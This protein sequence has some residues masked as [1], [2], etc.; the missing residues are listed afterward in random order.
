MS[1][2]YR[3]PG[4]WSFETSP[5]FAA[6]DRIVSEDGRTVMRGTVSWVGDGV[7]LAAAPNLLRALQMVAALPAFEPDE[8]YG[9]AVLAA[10][11]EA[12]GARGDLRNG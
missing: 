3:T 11:A 10:I 12:T 7:L 2:F 1:G 5:R 6:G 9:Q 4:P 8:P